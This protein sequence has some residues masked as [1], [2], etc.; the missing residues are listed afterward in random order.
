MA[1]PLGGAWQEINL[2]ALRLNLESVRA[3]VGPGVRIA[4]V[5]KADAYGH[6]MVECA[7]ALW[8]AGADV[9]ATASV[10]EALYLKHLGVFGA[11]SPKGETRGPAAL[12]S[13]GY[14]PDD[15]LAAAIVNGIALTVCDVGQA[16][17]LGETA[18]SRGLTAHAH[19]KIDTGFHRLGMT[20]DE[21]RA[22]LPGI[23]SMPGLAVDGVFTHLALIDED[24][25]RAQMDRF[26]SVAQPLADSSGRGPCL[27]AADSIAAFRYPKWR[28]GMVRVGAILYGNVI[29]DAPFIPRKVMRLCARIVSTRTIQ[30]GEGVGYD[31]TYRATRETII[32]AIPLGYADGL[33]RR[34]RE[35]GQASVRGVRVRYAGLPCMDQS[36]LDVTDVPGIQV[37]DI[38]TA[39]GGEGEDVIPVEEFAAWIG[40]NR[41]EP[42]A[43]TGRRVPRAYYQ[44][45][46]IVSVDDPLLDGFM[47]QTSFP[48]H[49]HP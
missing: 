5:V 27:H 6:G 24:H 17:R 42:L 26:F 10:R 19:V 21:A 44:N 29:A 22:D 1:S 16:R 3:A 31:G 35:R 13:M 45:G 40:S 49:I 4:A 18:M 20:I 12:W 34:L 48:Q 25:D 39:L 9:I 28:L 38:V 23:L 30:P 37:G 41:N 7:R 11:V 47:A 46:E 15:L 43:M 8:D 14:A 33:P 36:M 2:D 32:A